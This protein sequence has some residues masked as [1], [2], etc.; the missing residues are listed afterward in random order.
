MPRL[1]IDLRNEVSAFRP[2]A[3]A[4]ADLL[5]ELG[6]A[7]QADLVAEPAQRQAALPEADFALV[8]TFRA[9]EYRQAPRLRQLFTPAAGRDWIEPDPAGK[10]AAL[11]GSFHGP[12]IAQS[13]LAALLAAT[14]EL[15]TQQALQD[16]RSWDR[17]AFPRRRL[18]RGRQA[19]I[20]GCG[21]IGDEI[22]AVL[23]PLGVSVTGVRRSQNSAQAIRP[24][25][26][27][28]SSS[29]LSRLLPAAEI[30]LNLLPGTPEN[31]HF[32][33]SALLAQLPPG[34]I[35]ANFGRGTT[36]DESALLEAL[37]SG[38][39]GQAILDVTEIEPLPADSPLWSHPKIRLSPHSSCCYL[40][41]IPRFFA[42]A[43]PK[44]RHLAE[45]L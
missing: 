30:L 45:G 16:S 20:L 42:E 11:H 1:M 14:S 39:L 44:L 12:M 17:N 10:V 29:R 2:Q 19:L 21:A 26:T 38:R 15:D 36:Q 7:W 4:I 43:A 31:R 32:V 40:D 13:F 5:R 23:T 6:P 22:A 27:L 37:D 9:E 24:G 28:D 41:Y 3:E 18:L 34:A 33:D 25:F 35:Y 8:W